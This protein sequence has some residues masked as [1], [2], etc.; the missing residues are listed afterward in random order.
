MQKR[1][2]PTA[3]PTFVYWQ[4]IRHDYKLFL[5]QRQTIRRDYKVFLMQRRAIRQQPLGLPP[6]LA[7]VWRLIIHKKLQKS[8][9]NTHSSPTFY[10]FCT[11]QDAFKI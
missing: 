6:H 8:R 10:Y 1:R 3:Y 7:C 9:V 5:M 2:F 4:T 11:K